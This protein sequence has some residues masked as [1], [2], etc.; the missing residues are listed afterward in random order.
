MPAHEAG[1]QEPMP[2][3]ATEE[4]GVVEAAASLSSP[5]ERREDE[6]V[7]GSSSGIPRQPGTPEPW[8]QA[9]DWTHGVHPEDEDPLE[10]GFGI[11]EP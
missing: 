7:A 8:E 5:L 2:N 1:P 11:N 6:Q 4:F 3:T 10:L 9:Q